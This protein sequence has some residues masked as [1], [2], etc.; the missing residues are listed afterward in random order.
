MAGDPEA[1]PAGNHQYQFQSGE[2]L[3]QLLHITQ[4][5]EE[6]TCCANRRQRNKWH[7]AYTSS[8]SL[9]LLS[10]CLDEGE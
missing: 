3:F 4:D 9:P 7:F 6:S 10:F 8:A 5:Y 2:G 1:I